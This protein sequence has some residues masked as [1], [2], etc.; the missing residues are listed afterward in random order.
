VLNCINASLQ[1]QRQAAE[2]SAYT[3]IPHGAALLWA[4]IS[5]AP[6][7]TLNP[8]RAQRMWERY[9]SYPLGLSVVRL[10]TQQH[11]DFNSMHKASSVGAIYK[12]L[13]EHGNSC[14]LCLR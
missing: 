9:D 14:G 13:K 5:G 2:H 11:G 12:E 8:P 4:H 10:C 7:M 1:D 6:A 3:L